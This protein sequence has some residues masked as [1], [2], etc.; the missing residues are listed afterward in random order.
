MAN[1]EQDTLIFKMVRSI[2]YG[3]KI[4]HFLLFGMLALAMNL[5]FR[6]K[7]LNVNTFRV[8]WGTAVVLVFVSIEELSQYFIPGRTL[9]PMDFMAS[10]AGILLFTSLGHVVH[11]N[12]SY[13]NS[14]L[15]YK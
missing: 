5:V 4:G 10:V 9:D 2:S 6:L 14:S 13:R 1:T 3:D 12:Q 11:K 7:L 15:P 8:Y